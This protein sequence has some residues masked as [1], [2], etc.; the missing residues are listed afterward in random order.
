MDERLKELYNEICYCLACAFSFF[1]ANSLGGNH[2]Y[3]AIAPDTCLGRPLS[4]L[5]PSCVINHSLPLSQI[6]DTVKV[7]Q[8]YLCQADDAV[9]GLV[10]EKCPAGFLI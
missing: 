6:Y 2:S 9:Y 3:D 8:Y 10:Y 4:R 7:P 1:T 5:V